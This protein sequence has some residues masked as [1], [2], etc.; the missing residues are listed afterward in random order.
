MFEIATWKISSEIDAHEISVGM[1]VST[2]DERRH[3]IWHAHDAEF[4][5]YQQ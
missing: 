3:A 1:L 2:D 4:H 5:S